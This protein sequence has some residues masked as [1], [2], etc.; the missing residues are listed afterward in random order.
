MP[1]ILRAA[2]RAAS[3]HA[4][5]LT[6]APTASREHVG[7]L[8][9]LHDEAAE[10][11]LLTALVGRMPYLAC[12]LALG[13]C[14]AALLARSEIGPLLIWLTLVGAGLVAITRAYAIAISAPFERTH[15]RYFAQDL[16]AIALYIGLAWGTGSFLVWPA[17]GTLAQ[18][19]VFSAG[20][21]WL[22]SLIVR[23]PLLV[24]CFAIPVTVLAAAAALVRPLADGALA[25][26]AI[27]AAG[28]LV[29]VGSYVREGMIT[30]SKT[31]GLPP[32]YR[33]R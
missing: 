31:C 24:A 4:A 10:T 13:A 20:T 15:L 17:D 23:S 7:Q 19:L 16:R 9:D 5:P 32:S 30:R 18:A 21:S 22:V 6:D 3:P 1:A 12:G 8:A 29:L 14:I 25:G 26:A 28:V 2:I 27:L 11:A 33:T